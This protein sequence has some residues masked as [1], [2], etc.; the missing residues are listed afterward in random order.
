MHV[1]KLSWYSVL[2]GCLIQRSCAK[3]G[4]I[5]HILLYFVSMSESVL[6]NL[7][8]S[9]LEMLGE[10]DSDDHLLLLENGFSSLWLR[11]QGRPHIHHLTKSLIHM[12]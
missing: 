11:I 6:L 4:I 7:Q 8:V 9:L 2:N 1:L 5:H 10:L 3:T 12:Q